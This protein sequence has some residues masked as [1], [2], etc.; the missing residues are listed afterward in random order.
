MAY[1]QGMQVFSKTRLAQIK[2][3]DRKE[4]ATEGVKDSIKSKNLLFLFTARISKL[5]KTSYLVY[6]EK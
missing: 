3:K 5:L 4:A 6:W 1:C 2:S